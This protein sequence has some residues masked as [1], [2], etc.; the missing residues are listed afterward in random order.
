M[1]ILADTFGK[2]ESMLLM[3]LGLHTHKFTFRLEMSSAH[4]AN[5]RQN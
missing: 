4:D 1:L 5:A 3:D 2:S